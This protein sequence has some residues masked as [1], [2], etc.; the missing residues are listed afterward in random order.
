MLDIIGIMKDDLFV[1]HQKKFYILIDDLDR[2]WI[3]DSYRYELIGAMI[4]VIKELRQLKGVKI[5]ISLRENLNQLVF[6]GLMN[7]GGQREKLKPLY[8]EIKW[9]KS[10]LRRLLNK[11]L[12]MLSND[13][14]EVSEAFS[15]TRRNNKSGFD[16]VIERTYNRPRDL[17]AFINH[18]IENANNKSTFSFDI[19]NK[20]ESQYSLNRIEA[21]E[22]EWSENYGQFRSICLFLN[23]INNGFSLKSVNQDSFDDVYLDESNELLLKGELLFHTKSWQNNKINFSS[24]LKKVLY[25]LYRI[26]IIGVKKGPKYRTAFYYDTDV[27]ISKNDISNNCKFY[28]HPA[29]FSFFKVNTIEQLPED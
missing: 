23:G 3:E 2:E 28:V 10:D 5:I 27:I 12:K 1:D 15:K 21:L 17:I 7:K 6:S 16:Y 11:R 20:A 24:Y 14:L 26:G 25:I 13:E 29:L 4:E 19:L 22:D 8:S 18:A 9:S